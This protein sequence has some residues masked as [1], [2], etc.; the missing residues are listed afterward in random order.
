MSASHWYGAASSPSSS[1]SMG[2]GI[3]PSA[4][5]NSSSPAGEISS[6]TAAGSIAGVPEGVPLTARLED[7]I[8][9]SGFYLLITQDGPDPAGHDVGVLVLQV[10][11][12]HRCC[13]GT[14]GKEVL[15]QGKP[16]AGV[17]AVDHEAVAHPVRI[18][19]YQT[20]AV[21]KDENTVPGTCVLSS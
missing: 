10:M 5:K 11:T 15:N 20:L 13:Q 4:R 8:P 16:P 6:R 14:R 17:L 18:T 19:D 9:R 7:E 2:C 3:V 21:G 1:G 12:M